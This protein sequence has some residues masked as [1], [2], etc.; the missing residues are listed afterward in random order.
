MNLVCNRFE[1]C[2]EATAKAIRLGEK[3]IEIPIS[4]EPRTKEAGKKIRWTDAPDAFWTLL[5]HR[6]SRFKK[7]NDER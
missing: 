3:I 2:P 4:Y 7:I 5:R 6:F 1:F